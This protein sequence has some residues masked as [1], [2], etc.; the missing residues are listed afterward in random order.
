MLRP[1]TT[2]AFSNL[3]YRPKTFNNPKDSQSA[4]FKLRLP[5]VHPA[6]QRMTS[7][8]SSHLQ[9]STT[10][11]N[12]PIK[13]H[14]I[15]EVERLELYEPGG[16]HPVIINDLLHNRYR[17]VDKLGFGGYSTIWLARDERV[18]RYVAVKIGVASSSVSC[19]EVDVLKALRGSREGS[20]AA[21]DGNA[22]P[23]VLDAFDVCGS[24]GTHTCYT[25][26]PAQGNLKEASFSRL[27]PI[28][29]AR[30]L[31]AKLVTAVA[32][33][34]SRGFVHGDIH[35]RNVLI[36][37]PSTLDALS[38]PEFRQKFGAPEM[39]PVTRV[40]RKTLP[41]NVPAQA[42]LPLYLGKKAQDFTLS[43]AQNL[44]LSDFGEAFAPATEH[45]L[46][47]DCHIP[48]AVRAPE[49]L[50]EPDGR[51][52][53]AS[54]VWS[55]GIAVWEI[56]GMKALFGEGETRD[57]IVAQCIDVLGSEDFPEKWREVWERSGGEEKYADGDAMPRR[58]SRERE[59]WPC[60]DT[61]F[62][63]FVNKYRRKREAGTFEEEETRTILQLVR[64]MLRFR[65]EERMTVDE[66]L[67]SE[68]M[69]KWA[70]P[71]LE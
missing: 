68:W 30:A 36:N 9:F 16:Y 3:K 42:V 43:D 11:L 29:V 39:V 69:V 26:T 62:E 2:P 71:E 23:S 70:L 40:D 33:V 52:S 46:G 63:Q 49:A 5:C 67:G 57:A 58:H 6:P 22:L 27:F 38:V 35:L 32:F 53:Y 12:P 34:H 47:R 48:L 1:K 54:D 44:L 37:L 61:A 51:L 8:G 60:L 25:L 7:T 64:G 13:Y 21:V 15:D 4:K 10:S 18:G 20:R 55:L 59:T 65:P 28:R 56:L 31:A 41:P 19:K 14:W 66:V 45:R 24:N 50:F 17:I